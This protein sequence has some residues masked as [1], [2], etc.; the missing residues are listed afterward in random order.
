MRTVEVLP[1]DSAVLTAAV[2]AYPYLPEDPFY[3]KDRTYALRKI[4]KGG[5]VTVI[6]PAWVGSYMLMLCD[7]KL[8]LVMDVWLES[9]VLI[10]PHMPNRPDVTLIF[11]S[12]ETVQERLA[13]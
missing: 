4:N 8:F 12:T 13:V 9:C 3:E 10:N 1:G 11:G 6:S 2:W 7:G 5:I